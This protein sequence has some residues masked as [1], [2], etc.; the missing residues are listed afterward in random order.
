MNINRNIDSLDLSMREPIIFYCWRQIFTI[1]M[2]LKQAE[3]FANFYDFR[4]LLKK[5]PT[6]ADSEL[7]FL[8]FIWGAADSHWKKVIQ[9]EPN[10]NLPAM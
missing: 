3:Q 10:D 7:K 1:G 2:E 5:S 4:V 9:S 8:L 6:R